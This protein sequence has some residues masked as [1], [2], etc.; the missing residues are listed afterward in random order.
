MRDNKQQ[1]NT[2]NNLGTINANTYNVSEAK[3]FDLPLHDYDY[4][5]QTLPKHAEQ[6]VQKT[7]K[8]KFYVLAGDGYDKDELSKYIAWKLIGDDPAISQEVKVWVNCANL[9]DFDLYL[10]KKCT[11]NIFILRDILPHNIDNNLSRLYK[12]AQANI[13]Y[14]ILITNIDKEKW[15]LEGDVKRLFWQPQSTESLYRPQDLLEI[16]LMKLKEVTNILPLGLRNREFK[17]GDPLMGNLLLTEVVRDLKSPQS[18]DVFIHRLINFEKDSANPLNTNKKAIVSLPD[19]HRLIEDCGDDKRRLRHWYDISLSPR[20]KLIALG[21]CL[22]DGFYDEQFFA[23][24]EILIEHSWHKWEPTL[25]GLDYYDLES[26]G[27]YYSLN[28]LGQGGI[29]RVE[30]RHPKM[31]KQF[32]ETLWNS[33]R[34]QIFS[35]LPV[36]ERL[37]KDSV[38]PGLG[39]RELYGTKQRCQIL[40]DE[41]SETLCCIGLRSETSIKGTRLEETLLS[42]ASVENIEVQAVVARAIAQWRD[43][44]QD[45]QLFETIQ[46]W[47]D[48]KTT[49]LDMIRSFLKDNDAKGQTQDRE[50]PETYIKAT[51]ALTVGFAAQYDLPNVMN[52]K[53]CHLLKQLATDT[54]NDFILERFSRYTLPLVVRLHVNQLREMLQQMTEYAHLNIAIGKS[55]AIAYDTNPLEVVEILDAWVDQ[56]KRNRPTHFSHNELSH[57][58]KILATAAIAYGWMQYKKNTG[59][60]TIDDGFRRLKTML[61]K[62]ISQYVR[63]AAMRAIIMQVVNNFENAADNIKELFAVMHKHEIADFVQQLVWIYLF[64]RQELNEGDTFFR[65][66]NKK[67]NVWI[68]R[69]Q[70]LTQ[71]EKII[72]RWLKDSEDEMSRQIAFKFNFSPELNNF[73]QEEERFVKQKKRKLQDLEEQKEKSKQAY[74]APTFESTNESETFFIVLASWLATLKKRENF[75]I[76]R[77]LLPEV[78]EQNIANRKILD[79]V[80]KRMHRNCDDEIKIIAEQLDTA[81]S[82][83]K[84]KNLIIIFLVA[85]FIIFLFIR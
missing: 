3:F 54:T 68:Y 40:R 6:L 60:L 63:N 71:V 55:L 82:I 15:K 49:I 78:I 43:Y 30:S 69:D 27:H 22:F 38:L 77:S 5:A 19:L 13:H 66:D 23:A 11:P 36:M 84:K 37:V 75:A 4:K 35:T 31:R 42:L 33:H 21:L 74:Y 29:K 64:Q 65:W 12:T 41:I 70:S 9:Q 8:E 73:R 58:E 1:I 25:K 76:I 62:E 16:L 14:I 50:P 32:L 39:N 7:K 28:S 53:L 61:G 85:V 45:E 83:R 72:N 57:P 46:R 10:Q 47:Q 56:Y 59:P 17:K 34:R 48:H 18:I 20:E 67:Y 81:L 80:L 26:L 51:V 52:D 24:M 2:K 79:F 44:G